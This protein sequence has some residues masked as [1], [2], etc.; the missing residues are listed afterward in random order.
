V[1]LDVY[2][3]QWPRIGA[4][5]ALALSGLLALFG[6]RLPQTRRLSAAN[7]VA[8]L[9]H[10]FE[11]YVFPGYFPGQF[12]RGMFHSDSPRNYPL[13]P[14][15]AMI[16]N[17]ALAYP[18]YLGPALLRRPKWLGLAAVLLGWAQVVLHGVV[19]PRRAGDRYGPGFVTA[20]LLHVPI[21]IAYVKALNDE[22]PI[23][24]R[25]WRNGVAGAVVAVVGGLV[26]PN[27]ALR[28]RN[29]PYEFTAA[30]MG[31]HDVEPQYIA[32]IS[33]A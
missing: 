17:T 30:Q 28:D 3:R 25:D 23:S 33:S 7:L 8:L 32:S 31:R 27:L 13:N 2:R 9:A 22:D 5:F 26:V 6:G 14:Q 20:L 21:G 18:F 19:L 24:A 11:E 29:S 10:Q 16:I 4:V 1:R 12:N 15:S